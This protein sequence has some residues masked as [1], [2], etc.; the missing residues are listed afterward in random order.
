MGEEG[1]SRAHR[2]AACQHRSQREA[3]AGQVVVG[4]GVAVAWL[5]MREIKE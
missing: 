4:G 1:R 2:V 5:S 3:T